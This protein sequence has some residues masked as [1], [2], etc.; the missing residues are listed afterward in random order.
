MKILIVGAGGREHALAWKIATSPL[1]RR[2]YVAP[3]NGGTAEW[4]IPVA[5]NDIAG[6]TE[7]ARREKV[8]LTVVGPEEPLTLGL[9]D[10][11]RAENLTVFG[12]GREAARLEGSKA[13]AKEVMA[14]AGAPTAASRV[15]TEQAAACAYIEKTGTPVVVKADGLAAGKG[16]IVTRTAAEAKQ[17]VHDVMGGAF[18]RAGERIVV[19]E[20]LTG[21]EVSLL[22]FCDGET[23]RPMTAVQDHKRIFDGDA[24]P[25]TGGMGVCAP[26]SFW[27]PAL[28][29]EAME[30]VV[31]P[32]LREMR[33]RG[34][35]FTGVL[36]VGLMLT[37]AGL[38]VLEYNVRFGDPET[39]AL[40]MLLQSDLV[41]LLLACARGGGLETA[42]VEWRPEAAVCVVM[43]APG[44]PGPYAKDIPLALPQATPEYAAIF[45]AGTALRDGAYLSAGGRVLGVTA[46][47]ADLTAARARAYALTE[48]IGFPGARF[49]RDIAGVERSGSGDE[50]NTGR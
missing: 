36:F 25:N 48:K 7:F 19:E 42:R 8:D 10:A 3:G 1:C 22:C 13:F 49:R 45:H 40:M 28:E 35:P 38:R 12:P 14:K 43:A 24:G 29:A 21:P 18:G 26:P 27:T 37:D 23:A 2:L 39:Q 20:R 41:P 32:T 16:V 33:R 31:T 6:L 47:G 11:L 30:R 4:N 15:F 50:K 5:A 46:R 44:Y 9:A 17:A 34:A